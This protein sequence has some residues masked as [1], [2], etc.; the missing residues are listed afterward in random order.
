MASLVVASITCGMAAMAQGTGPGVHA[1]DFIVERPT[2]VSL[3]FEWKISGDVNRNSSV[4][5]SWRKKGE[6]A[7]RKAL[8]MLRMNG[9]F[10]QGPKPEYGDLNYYNYAV[11]NMFAGSILGL[12][13]DTEYECHFVLSDPDGVTG[14]SE[15]TVTLRTRK[16]PKP[17]LGGHVYHVYPFGYKGQMQQPAFT[18]LMTAYFLGSD[19]SD[20]SNIFGPRVQPGDTILVHAG[21]YTDKR[22]VYGGIVG[23]MKDPAYGTPFDGTYYLTASGTPDRPIVIKAAGDG[24]VIFDGDGAHNLFNL[25]AANYNY[26]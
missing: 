2:L 19:E 23:T 16:E 11:P 1:G 18:G 26:F 15:Q 4:T 25:E 6:Q 10:V 14:T 12:E 9:E 13:P 21:V 8:P 5:V 22:F 24:E 20:H 17:M 3:G 7:W